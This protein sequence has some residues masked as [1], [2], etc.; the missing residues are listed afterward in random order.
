MQCAQGLLGF[1]EHD[2]ILGTHELPTGHRG[3][4]GHGTIYIYTIGHVP[5]VAEND[6][7]TIV[8]IAAPIGASFWMGIA[9]YKWSD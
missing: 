4:N 7:A 5:P 1:E 8:E 2:S 6:D 3:T 9:A